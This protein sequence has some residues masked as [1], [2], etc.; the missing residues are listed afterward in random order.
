[1]SLD[2]PRA[3]LAF[4]TRVPVGASRSAGS[5]AVKWF[6]MV[7][8]VI[9]AMG[10]AVYWIVGRSVGST[11]GAVAAVG[12]AVLVTG[13]LH[14]DG[15]ADTFDGL[16]STRSRERQLEIMDDS[17]LGAFGVAALTLMLVARVG[18]VSELIA[19]PAAV[20]ALAWCHAVSRAA[21]VL[22]MTASRPASGS[23]SAVWFLDGLRTVPAATVAVATMA[24]GWF[25]LG[26]DSVW[27][28]PLVAAGPV[29]VAVWSHRRIG[30]ITGDVLGACQQVALVT[31]LV[32]VAA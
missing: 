17:R 7:G 19:E 32:G 11:A 1:M 16:S 12:L 5:A 6:P 23:G 22:V 2:A 26:G 28:L 24:A 18:L 4:L 29:T 13:A 8:A 15:L 10:G 30:G 20:A 14:E 21:C 31:A 9:G 25:L 3:A 27:A